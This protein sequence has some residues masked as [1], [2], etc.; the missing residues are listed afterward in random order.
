MCQHTHTHP[1]SQSQ[2]HTHTHL[3]SVSEGLGSSTF[4]LHQFLLHAA[5]ASP[6]LP[7]LAAARDLL[8]CSFV[9]ELCVFACVSAVRSN[10]SFPLTCY[11]L[12]GMLEQIVSLFA[13]NSAAVVEQQPALY[14][15]ASESCH[16]HVVS[17]HAFYFLWWQTRKTGLCYHIQ[18]QYIETWFYK[19]FTQQL[20][21]YC[22][23]SGKHSGK[24]FCR[25]AGVCVLVWFE[26]VSFCEV[27]A[28][29]IFTSSLV[30]L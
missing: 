7:G 10:S 14:N 25:T 22:S 11:S 13:L 19:T 2:T 26:C 9:V 3:G 8:T 5:F 27:L 21:S 15:Q 23:Q 16:Q 12:S 20:Y 17:W 24:S 1:L 4:P 30:L 6:G 28:V 18:S 29:S